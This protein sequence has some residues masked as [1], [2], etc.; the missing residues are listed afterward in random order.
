MSSFRFVHRISPAA[1]PAPRPIQDPYNEGA[2]P[3]RCD[4]PACSGAGEKARE[5]LLEYQADALSI[6]GITSR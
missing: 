4:D 2:F 6:R 3:S 1:S 5:C